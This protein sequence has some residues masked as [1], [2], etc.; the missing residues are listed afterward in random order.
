MRKGSIVLTM[1]AVAAL[2]P[3]ASAQQDEPGPLTWIAFS[4]VKSGKTQDA[5]QMTLEAQEF[6]DG[7]MAD[8][9]ILGWGL[10]TPVHHFPDD[11]WN[12]LEWVN[13]PSWEKVGVW[14]DAVVQ[15]FQGLGEDELQARQQRAEEIYEAGSHWDS[16]TRS[17]IF[18]PAGQGAAPP[19][20]F[21][22]GTFTAKPGQDAAAV[23]WIKDFVAPIA[24]ELQAE[25]VIGAYGLTTPELHGNDDW[26]HRV[27]YALPD[28]GSLDKLQTAIVAAFGPG[29][30]AQAAATFDP[31]NHEDRILMIL[32]WGGQ[33]QN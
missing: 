7:M 19:R 11:N 22:A 14:S 25:G 28:L 17:L 27:W 8:G 2:A 21:A 20:Y 26:T 6:M 1:L 10:A 23:Q 16:V 32:H 15:Y 3:A 18:K 31:A 13:V 29:Q 24:D 33:N 9:T 30:K 12:H 5:V 4:K